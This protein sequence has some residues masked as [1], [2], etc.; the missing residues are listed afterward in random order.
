MQNDDFIKTNSFNFDTK[1]KVTVKKIKEVLLETESIATNQT[2]EV[3]VREPPRYFLK[4]DISFKKIDSK[5]TLSKFQT[6]KKLPNKV[7]KTWAEDLDLVLRDDLHKTQ[8]VLSRNQKP[9][10]HP[11]TQTQPKQS[12]YPHETI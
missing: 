10:K 1:Q 12:K 5:K 3:E 8:A 9:K 7:D 2:C 11:T 6:P 4:S